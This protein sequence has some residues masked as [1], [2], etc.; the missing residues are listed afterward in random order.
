MQFLV[1]L[2]NPGPQYQRTRHNVG[3]QVLDALA[4]ELGAPSFHNQASFKAEVSKASDVILIKPQTFM[5]A[6]GEAA[7]AVIAFYSGQAAMAA[8]SFDNVFVIHDDLDLELGTFKLQFGV[9]P[10]V[11]NGLASMGQQLGTDKYWHVRVGVDSRQGDR[12]IPGSEYVLQPFSAD[13]L[14]I[15]EQTLPQVVAAVSARL[16]TGS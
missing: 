7:R 15:L 11:H 4:V 10:K 16:E 9:G 13:E 5:N 12:Q 1:G 14:A 8:Q 6:S 2:G 3:W